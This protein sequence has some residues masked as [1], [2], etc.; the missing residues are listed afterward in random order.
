MPCA[1]V[2]SPSNLLEISTILKN[3]FYKVWTTQEQ[4]FP[5]VQKFLQL[6]RPSVS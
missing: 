1:Y 3:A 5:Y 4:P 6:K 2:Q